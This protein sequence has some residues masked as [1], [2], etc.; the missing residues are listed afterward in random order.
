AEICP[1]LRRIKT[2]PMRRRILPPLPCWDCVLIWAGTLSLVADRLTVSDRAQINTQ[3]QQGSG[4]NIRLRIGD[5]LIL[6]RQGQ[7]SATADTLVSGGNG[8]NIDIDTGFIV[9]PALENSDITANALEGSGGNVAIRANALLGIVFRDF[10]TP[11][12]DITASSQFGLAGSVTIDEYGFSNDLAPEATRLSAALADPADRLI[13]GCLLDEEAHFVVTGR[14]GI[15]ANP[16]EIL[17]QGLIWQDPRGSREGSTP[18]NST[19]ENSVNE[20]AP[21]SDTVSRPSS[22]LAELTEA[23]GWQINEQG[24]VE[25]FSTSNTSPQPANKRCPQ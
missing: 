2:S 6:R 4:G 13:V 14:G 21:E 18:D 10:L 7:I 8:G 11:L 20:A 22:T 9:A 24:N 19:Q 5:V 25:L 17:N 12:S 23:Q 16:S 15:P 3:S 1:C